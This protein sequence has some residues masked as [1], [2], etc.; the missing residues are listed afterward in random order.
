MDSFRYHTGHYMA[1]KM[2][3]RVLKLLVVLFHCLFY[4]NKI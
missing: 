3:I 2:H 1:S 4:V